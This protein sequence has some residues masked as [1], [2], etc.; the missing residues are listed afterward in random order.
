MDILIGFLIEIEQY[1]FC[2]TFFGLYFEMSM[3]YIFCSNSMVIYALITRSHT[4][5]VYIFTF[6]AN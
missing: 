6:T 4:E 5:N 3:F 1:I 2:I